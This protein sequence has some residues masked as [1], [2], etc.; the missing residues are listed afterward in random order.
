MNDG[1]IDFLM[2]ISFSIVLGFFI[3]LERHMTGHPAE[4]RTN[5]LICMGSCMFL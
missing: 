2:R 4:I 5:I 3:V 1:V